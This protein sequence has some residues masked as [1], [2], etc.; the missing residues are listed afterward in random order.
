VVADAKINSLSAPKSEEMYRPQLQA[1]WMA[2]TFVVRSN[3]APQPL[4]AA[5]REQIRS[6][7]PDLPVSGVQSLDQLV[8]DS[9]GQPRLL[10]ALVGAFAAFALLLA[11]IGIYGVM[12]YSVSHRLREMGIRMALG[13][14][15]RDIV[16][17]VVGQGMRLVVAGLAIGFVAS[18][19][20]TKFLASELFGTQPK[21]PATFAL[22]AA[23]LALVALAACLIPARRAMRVD[24]MVALRY[25]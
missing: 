22:V 11:A 13:A 10:T 18:L 12:A 7:D 5:V 20:L 14:S 21:D 19:W 4:V 25:E 9:V 1:P 3:S 16:R 23:G 6:I 8:S 2:M 24:P 15:P 17:M